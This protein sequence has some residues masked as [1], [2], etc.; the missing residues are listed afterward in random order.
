MPQ[1]SVTTN[2][3]LEQQR[4]LLDSN[5]TC[6][7]TWKA[8]A[9]TKV[10]KMAVTKESDTFSRGKKSSRPPARNWVQ[11]EEVFA[12]DRSSF[13]LSKDAARTGINN[14]GSFTSCRSYLTW[15]RSS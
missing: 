6:L 8:R 7:A 9:S 14:T 11:K 15:T 5:S 1:M 12:E 2:H 4:E 3:R 13:Q 10:H